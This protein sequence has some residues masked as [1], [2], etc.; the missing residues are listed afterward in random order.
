M[1]QLLKSIPIICFLITVA[2]NS[3]A[4]DPFSTYNDAKPKGKID[5]VIIIAENADGKHIYIYNK[6]RQLIEVTQYRDQVFP[7]GIGRVF[8]TVK[9]QYTYGANGHLLLGIMIFKGG[10]KSTAR[11]IYTKKV[12]VCHSGNRFSLQRHFCS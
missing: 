3:F 12:W 7:D 4:Q 6:H 11:Y 8:D 5:T 2:I 9:T 10:K 1:R